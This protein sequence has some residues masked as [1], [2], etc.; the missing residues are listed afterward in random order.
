MTSP[1][2]I[3]TT[4]EAG[5][6]A[7]RNAVAREC[8]DALDDRDAAYAQLHDALNKCNNANRRTVTLVARLTIL[9]DDKWL[10]EFLVDGL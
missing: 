9:N 2:P 7:G 6:T 4:Y 10:S 3:G 1:E 5:W 8:A